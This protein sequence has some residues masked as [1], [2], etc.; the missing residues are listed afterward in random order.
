VVACCHAEF[1]IAYPLRNPSYQVLPCGYEQLKALGLFK[2]IAPAGTR[3]GFLF[4]P[5]QA[6][7]ARL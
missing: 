1:E 6:G 7:A 3:I 4:N 5:D 2:Q